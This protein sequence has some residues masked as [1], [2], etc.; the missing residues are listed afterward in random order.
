MVL[1]AVLGT[2]EEVA[3]LGVKAGEAVARQGLHA[4]LRVAEEVGAEFRAVG[5]EPAA[6]A[7]C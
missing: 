7:G 5:E 6:L 2:F 4:D 3:V 1:P